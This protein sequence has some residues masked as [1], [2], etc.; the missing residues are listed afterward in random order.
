MIHPTAIIDER[1]QIG[2]GV[3]IGAYAV[4]GR[5][6]TIGDACEIGHHA[7]IEGPTTM[8]EGNRI[9]PFAAI[10]LEPQDMKFHGEASRLEIGSGNLIREYVTLNRGSEAGGWVTRIGDQNWIM[11]YCHIAHDC[12]IGS[13]IIMA[14][15]TTLGG[16]VVGKDH[17]TLGGMTGV[18]QFCRIGEYAMTGGQSMITQ[19]IT[20]YVIAVGNRAKLQGL[21]YVGLER[22][23]FTPAQIEEINKI[24]RVF[25]M[26]GKTVENAVHQLRAELPPSEHL[27]RFVEFVE[28]SQRGVC[29]P[30]G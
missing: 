23:G 4:I 13:N 18:H 19:D 21:N 6:V 16:H 14:N 5:E 24:Y 29:R 12:L 25:F 2:K 3:K 7:V 9:F 1:A 20:P 22:K 30:T 17:A 8:G 28:S 15:G 26:S 27:Q 11:A 10:G